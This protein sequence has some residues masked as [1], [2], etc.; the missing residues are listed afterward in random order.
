MELVVDHWQE[1]EGAG[2]SMDWMKGLEAI[3]NETGREV[4]LPSLL[5]RCTWSLLGY[6]P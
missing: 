1:Q 2:V 3:M 6:N 4:V 5:R